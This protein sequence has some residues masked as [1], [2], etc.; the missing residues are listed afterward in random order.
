M[1]ICNHCGDPIYKFQKAVHKGCGQEIM[2]KESMEYDRK[3]I[4]KILEYTKNEPE[5]TIG[6]IQ[7]YYSKRYLIKEK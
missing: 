4:T 1:F 6:E 5:V 2:N 3:C 7:E